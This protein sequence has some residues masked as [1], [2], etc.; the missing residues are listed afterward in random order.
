MCPAWFQASVPIELIFQR[1]RGLEKIN[2]LWKVII[3]MKNTKLGEEIERLKI[4]EALSYV[5]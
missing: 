5:I 1:K 2:T 3:V 4:K